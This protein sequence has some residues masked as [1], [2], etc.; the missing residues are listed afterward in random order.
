MN[1]F[2]KQAIHN[3]LSKVIPELPSYAVLSEVELTLISAAEDLEWI[4][5]T[6]NGKNEL[7]DLGKGALIE[8]CEFNCSEGGKLPDMSLFTNLEISLSLVDKEGATHPVPGAVKENTLENNPESPSLLLS[9]F[10]EPDAIV[11]TVFGH[12]KLSDE[13]EGVEA[14]HDCTSYEG[15]ILLSNML[16]NRFETLDSTV[17]C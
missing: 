1:I 4:A 15:A 6:T 7:T 13:N 14:L 11:F 16:C 2:I 8:F 5:K 9:D 10:Q 17:L 12:Y 3:T